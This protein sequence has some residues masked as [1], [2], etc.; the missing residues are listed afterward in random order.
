[1]RP[2]D[3]L[4]IAQFPLTPNGKIDVHA[5]PAIERKGAK[6]EDYVAPTNEVETQ[7]CQI[8]QK[9]LKIDRVRVE[10]TFLP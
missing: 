3:Y 10:D 9:V 6:D 7:L 1:M 5:L 4:L 2:E 8:W